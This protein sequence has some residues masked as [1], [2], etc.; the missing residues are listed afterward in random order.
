[1]IVDS[2]RSGPSTGMP[3]K[4][5]QS[6]LN[7]ALY[8]GHGEAPRVV[9]APTSVEDCFQVIVEAFNAAE[10]FQVP[11]IVLTD[12]SL[13]HRL[14]TVRRPDLDAWTWST[15]APE[16]GRTA[17]Y[18]PLRATRRRRLP[19]GR[20][21]AARAPYIS[22][23][24]RA[25]RG[26][27]P[28]LRARDPRGDDGQAVP[29]ARAARART[30]RITSHGA[31]AAPTSAL[32]GLGLDRGRRAGG[33]RRSACDRGRQGAHVLPA[34]LAPLPVERIA[35]GRAADG[36]GRGARAERHRAS[37]R[38]S[39]ART[40]AS[41]VASYARRRPALHG[42]ADRDSDRRRSAGRP[43]R[44]RGRVRGEHRLTRSSRRPT[45]TSPT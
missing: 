10:R 22:T 43:H 8:G 6:D 35:N 45:T 32:I 14:E 29:Q 11:V 15:G 41:R 2:Q 25:R 40:S 20:C 37:S 19:D 36:A 18:Q 5:E 17:T 13:R 16:P 9:M 27:Q 24:H 30:G 3:T 23:G 44:W 42:A 33:G 31:G 7:H 39:C 34:V 38:A 4:T 21:P 1:M 12:Q 28:A 26:R